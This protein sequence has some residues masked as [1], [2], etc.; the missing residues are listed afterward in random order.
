MARSSPYNR[1][2]RLTLCALF[3]ALFC[4]LSPIAIPIGPIPLSLGLL[5]ILL[6]AVVLPPAMSL[7][8]VAVF[9]AL[10]L[11]GLPVFAMGIGG[12]VALL[13]PTGGFLWSYLLI[14][15][16]VSCLSRHAKSLFGVALACAVA[17]PICYFCGTLQYCLITQ[18]SPLAALTVA[19]LPFLAFDLIKI[20][21]AA[22]VGRLIKKHLAPTLDR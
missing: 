12:T 2:Q 11:C 8:S 14:T 9:L 22:Y 21:A 10:G 4:V 18:V 20:F 15:P 6:A 5:G 16:L 1:L 13:S 3:S 17:L 19:V 7:T